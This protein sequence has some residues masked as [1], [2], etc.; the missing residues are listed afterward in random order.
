MKT[1][2]C[3][4][5]GNAMHGRIDKKFCDDACRTEYNNRLKSDPPYVRSVNSILKKNRSII[6][7]LM[8]QDLRRVKVNMQRLNEYGF[9]FTFYTH[10]Y[11]TRSGIAFVFCYEYGY[12]KLDQNRCLLLKRNA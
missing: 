6:Q 7:K 8:P 4:N 5:C 12:L 2:V 3:Q 10:S 11:T 9:N 1:K